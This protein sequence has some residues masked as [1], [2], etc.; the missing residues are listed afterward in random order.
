MSRKDRQAWHLAGRQAQ[1]WFGSV[2]IGCFWRRGN[3]ARHRLAGGVLGLGV[4]AGRQSWAAPHPAYQLTAKRRDRYQSLRLAWQ[5][6][7][8]NG[9]HPPVLA[10]TAS[11]SNNRSNILHFS[12]VETRLAVRLSVP[13]WAG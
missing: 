11:S 2:Q 7:L 9:Q 5:R 10:I 6:D 1:Y 13:F 12:R 8:A 3:R 4:E